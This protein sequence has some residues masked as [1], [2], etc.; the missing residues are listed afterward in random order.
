MINLSMFVIMLIVAVSGILLGVART[1]SAVSD[2]TTGLQNLWVHMHIVTCVF[3]LLL[4]TVHL[5]LHIP[6]IKKLPRLLAG[7]RSPAYREKR[8]RE[9]ETEWP[10][11]ETSAGT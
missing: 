11:S 4:I 1:G 2:Q 7:G 8:K 10:E 3:F 5:M 6:Y 9:G